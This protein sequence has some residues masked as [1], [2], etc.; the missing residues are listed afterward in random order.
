MTRQ[1]FTIYVEA[2]QK[3]LRRFLVALCCGDTALADDI[4]QE[5]YVK[6]YLSADG[7]REESKFSSWVFRI[8][9]NTFVSYIRCSRVTMSLDTAAAECSASRSDDAFR[10]QALYMALDKLTGKERTAILLFYMEG[11]SVAEIAGIIETSED[12]VR[13]QLSRGRVHLRKMLEQ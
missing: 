9:Y 6:A 12:A 8:A 4:A 1:Q 2:T 7:F 11:Y 13:Q 3:E 10:Y 5:T